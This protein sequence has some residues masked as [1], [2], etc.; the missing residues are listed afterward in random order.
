MSKSA[1]AYL[2]PSSLISKADVARL[3]REVETLDNALETQKVRAGG[4][5]FS[6]HMPVTSQLLSDFVE[7]NKLD[8][9]N[10]KVRLELKEQLQALKEKASTMHMTFASVAD[11]ESLGQLV[12]WIRQNIHPQAL[13]SVGLQPAIVGGVYLRTPNHVHDFSLKSMLA[14]K[15]E[16]ITGGLES[17]L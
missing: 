15:R 13:L 16:L 12:T 17:L 6:Y 9:A 7:L 8:L 5:Q 3:K 11:P 10:D 1:D 2:L 14:G 4:Q